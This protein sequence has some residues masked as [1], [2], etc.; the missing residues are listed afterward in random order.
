MPSSGESARIARPSPV[1]R[2]EPASP[3][4]ALIR[5]R[6]Y[7]AL[8]PVCRDSLLLCTALALGLAT[9]GCCCPPRRPVLAT[10]GSPAPVAHAPRGEREQGTVPPPQG[11]SA[12][13]PMR[14]DPV[15]RPSVAL[16]SELE[17]YLRSL[18]PAQRALL[19]QLAEPGGPEK[20]FQ[21]LSPARR[22]QIEEELRTARWAV[23]QLQVE[24]EIDGQLERVLAVLREDAGGERI[25]AL[26]DPMFAHGSD[27]RFALEREVPSRVQVV[28]ERSKLN[29][30]ALGRTEAPERQAILR[31]RLVRL[32]VLARGATPTRLGEARARELVDGA[33]TYLRALE[34]EQAREVLA[35]G[36]HRPTPSLLALAKFNPAWAAL[37][38]DRVEGGVMIPGLERYVT[39]YGDGR[40]NLNTAD[41]LVLQALFPSDPA[42]AERIVARR[43]ALPR[44][45]AGPTAPR[46]RPFRDVEELRQLEGVNDERLLADGVDLA[47]D[48]DVRSEV[49]SVFVDVT[50]DLQRRREQ[51]VVERRYLPAVAGQPPE[52]EGFARLLHANLSVELLDPSPLRAR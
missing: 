51:L 20:Y 18:D 45:G 16:T 28:D 19:E 11:S 7:G 49:F 30:L 6:L 40:V 12:P 13:A 52:F 14:R 34:E 3:A 9:L 39:T 22:A 15:P 23:D 48:L 43:P 17:E 33:A 4:S 35:P 46:A 47:S 2:R 44:P 5:A 32:L 27:S 42:L 24:N 10:V 36:L 25:D 41:V 29:L 31:E 21:S 38:H 8:G 26:A 37:L 50:S 1:P